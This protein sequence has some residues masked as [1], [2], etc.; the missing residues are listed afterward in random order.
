VEPARLQASG[1]K[2]R[3]PTLEGALRNAVGA[4]PLPGTRHG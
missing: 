1:F 3:F 2:Y 4:D